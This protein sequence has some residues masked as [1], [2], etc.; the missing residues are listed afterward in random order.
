[1]WKTTGRALRNRCTTRATPP[2]HQNP[3]RL[4]VP[5]FGTNSPST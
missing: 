4:T 2:N 1:M 3:T 5:T